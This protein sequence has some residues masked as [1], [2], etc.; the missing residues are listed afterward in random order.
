MATGFVEVYQPQVC[1]DGWSLM[2][3]RREADHFGV[4]WNSRSRLRPPG[5]EGFGETFLASLLYRLKQR[6]KRWQWYWYNSLAL[7]APVLHACVERWTPSNKD[8]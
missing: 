2:I 7:K 5:R 6:M 4:S 8:K 3:G 1:N